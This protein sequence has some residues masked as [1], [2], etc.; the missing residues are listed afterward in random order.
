[1]PILL[2]ILSPFLFLFEILGI[3]MVG[4]QPFRHAISF[5]GQLGRLFSI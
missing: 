2:R 5:R 4:H 3:L 1:M